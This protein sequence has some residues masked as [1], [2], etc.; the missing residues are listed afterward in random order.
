[1]ARLI[2]ATHTSA[3]DAV[4]CS[5]GPPLTEASAACESVQEMAG[6]CWW[7]GFSSVGGS[8]DAR[9]AVRSTLYFEQSALAGVQTSALVPS[10]H[11]IRSPEPLHLTPPSADPFASFGR[12]SQEPLPNNNSAAPLRPSEVIRASSHRL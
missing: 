12:Q 7:A 3:H 11:S 2:S 6:S 5:A 9:K 10:G 4:R 8:I 1:M